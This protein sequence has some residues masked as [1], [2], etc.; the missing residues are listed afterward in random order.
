L[1]ETDE[2]F[3]KKFKIN[4]QQRF[5]IKIVVKS[6]PKPFSNGFFLL[7]PLLKVSFQQLFS[8]KSVVKD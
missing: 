3:R 8:H 4:L 6:L 5:E 2:G 1:G 7:E